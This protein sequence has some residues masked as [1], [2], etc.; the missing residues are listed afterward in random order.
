MHPFIRIGPFRVGLYGLMIVAGF[1]VATAVACLRARRRGGSAV[2]VIMLAAVVYGSAILGAKLGYW[3]TA[4][5]GGIGQ[6]FRDLFSGNFMPIIFGGLVF[7][8]GLILAVIMACLTIKWVKLDFVLY[9]E[10]IVPVIPLGHAFGRVGCL[11]AG[12]CYGIPYEGFLHVHYPVIEDWPLPVGNRFP[13]QPLEALLDVILFAVL[14]V[15]TR[16]RRR[17][18][19]VLIA[20]MMGYSV[21]RFFDEFLRGD[22]ERGIYAGL[23]SSQ[24][25]SIGIVLAA[26]VLLLVRKPQPEVTNT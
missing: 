14:C 26:L 4:Y 15:Y 2:M 6:F 20:Y 18:Y 1:L 25:I 10:A 7:Y 21:I 22:A 17:K 12:C 5:E 11:L 24:W 23:A 3:F 19:D 16:R 8:G 13:V 9:S